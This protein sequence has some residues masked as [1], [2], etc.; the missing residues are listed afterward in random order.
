[1]AKKNY[2]EVLG[3][4]S[5]ADSDQIKKAFRRQAQ[6][7]H[8]DRNPDNPE[9]TEQFKEVTEA[10]SVLSDAQKRRIYDQHGHAGLE[11]GGMGF[12]PSGVDFT[13]SL[14]DMIENFFGMGSRH[15]GQSSR[16]RGS[17]RL[18]NYEITLEQAVFGDSARL[19]IPIEVTCKPCKG[20]GAASGTSP[21][22]C[23]QCNGSGY[24]NASQGI[25]QV[26]R[27]CPVCQGK[28]QMIVDPCSNCSGQGQVEKSHE[29]TFNIPAN[30]QSGNKLRFQGQGDSGFNGGPA[31]DLFVRIL[32]RPH[33]VFTRKGR[34]LHCTVP[35]SFVDLC[36]G[37]KIEVPT[38]SGQTYLEIPPGTTSGS[39]F[40]HKQTK[41]IRL[42]CRVRV[43]TP[44]SLT[45][46]Q[47][48][49]LAQFGE[50]LHKNEAKQA[51][52]KTEWLKKA[53]AFFS[54]GKK[55]KSSK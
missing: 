46:E 6:K 32:V 53:K 44:V 49:L 5:D 34:E 29:I 26:Q 12:N 22:P 7:Y 2:Y 11:S 1:M 55:E 17:D 27:T 28:G 39:V 54:A 35:I 15:K 43:E 24:L 42:M 10:Y 40:R 45:E 37:G 25:F 8:P 41:G 36:L 20:S 23:R 3:I 52:K 47:K 48:D 33:A 18:L 51:P 38:L 4:D 14:E 19:D 16:E 30:I 31:G 9:T 13:S 21:E 50:S